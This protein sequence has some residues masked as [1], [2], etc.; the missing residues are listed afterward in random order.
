M[1]GH[2]VCKKKSKKD[3]YS[4][5]PPAL[6]NAQV[7]AVIVDEHHGKVEIL[8]H[9]RGEKHVDI[10][11][12]VHRAVKKIAIAGTPGKTRTTPSSSNG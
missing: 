9:R 1:T 2:P 10:N 12:A 11:N 5:I 3:S 8:S 6:H 4:V 7:A